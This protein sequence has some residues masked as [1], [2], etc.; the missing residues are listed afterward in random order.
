LHW[1]YTF[2]G[3]ENPDNEG[4]ISSLKVTKLISYSAILSQSPRNEQTLNLVIKMVTRS[5]ISETFRRE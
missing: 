2:G 4:E 5:I 3:I 1:C